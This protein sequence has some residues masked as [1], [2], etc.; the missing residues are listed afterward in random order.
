M[1]YEI[2]I[3]GAAPATIRRASAG[4][5][6]CVRLGPAPGGGRRVEVLDQGP[7]SPK[8]TEVPCPEGPLEIEI[9]FARAS[10]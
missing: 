1:I 5:V 10:R 9:C 7:T 8:T 4:P 3:R 6:V 2:L